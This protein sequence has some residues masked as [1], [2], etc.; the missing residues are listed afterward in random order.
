MNIKLSAGNIRLRVT[1]SEL[2]MLLSSRAIKLEVALPRSHAFRVNVRPAVI[3]G[4]SLESDPTGSWIAIPRTELE[5]LSQSLP[6]RDGLEHSFELAT[7]GSVLVSFEVDV[8][9][10]QEGT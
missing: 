10:N 1:R 9:E 3:G 6:S 5:T 8:R 7:G 2:D 4:W